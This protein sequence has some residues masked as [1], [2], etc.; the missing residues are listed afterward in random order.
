MSRRSVRKYVLLNNRTTL[1]SNEG[2]KKMLKKG[3][4][5][6]M[7]TCGEAEYYKG[8]IWTCEG[9]EFTSSSGSQVVFLEGF[10][11]YFSVEYLQV[12]NLTSLNNKVK[13]LEEGLKMYKDENEVYETSTHINEFMYE[14]RPNEK[15]EIPIL[16]KVHGVEHILG[17][18]E[19]DAR[20]FNHIFQMQQMVKEQ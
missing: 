8:Q 7:H 14:L 20:S 13:L 16:I 1:R 2:G 4:T 11:G 15:D 5:V 9:D 19:K 18:T 10:S 3:D 6:V 17:I 12:V